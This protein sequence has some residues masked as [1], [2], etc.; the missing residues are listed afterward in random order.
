MGTGPR[1]PSD[2]KNQQA[3]TATPGVGL[4]TRRQ[5]RGST[6][7]RQVSTASRKQKTTQRLSSL[8]DKYW[9]D[10]RREEQ[11]AEARRREEANKSDSQ[12][13][14]TPSTISPFG[15]LTEEEKPETEQLDQTHRFVLGQTP[16]ETRG[17]ENQEETSGD[18]PEGDGEDSEEAVLR[19]VCGSPAEEGARSQVDG[20]PE[21]NAD[22]GDR[23]AHFIWPPDYQPCNEGMAEAGRV[24]VGIQAEKPTFDGEAG[25][26]EGYF[27]ALEVIRKERGWQDEDLITNAINGATDQQ[28]V[29]FQLRQTRKMLERARRLTWESFKEEVA[30]EYGVK[31]AEEKTLEDLE[32][33]VK[34]WSSAEVSTKKQFMQL[35]REFKAVSVDLEEVNDETLSV[36][37]AAALPEGN[38][39]EHVV[40]VLAARGKKPKELGWVESTL[41]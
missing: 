31:L 41:R 36:K 30:E 20:L 29:G 13:T 18:Q 12:D 10:K 26:L 16:D 15:E 38:M 11:E 23:T 28:E 40:S 22:D 6:V 32:K 4:S 2:R 3:E 17:T 14:A 39:K 21:T 34:K 7:V 37:F 25:S 1:T 35:R 19:S 8:P 33:V 5:A 27:I 24:V 9:D